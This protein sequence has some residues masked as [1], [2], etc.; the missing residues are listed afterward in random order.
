ME[1]LSAVEKSLPKTMRTTWQEK[2]LRAR[3]SIFGGANPAFAS[4]TVLIAALKHAASYKI[5]GLVPVRSQG[6]KTLFSK[7]QTA[8]LFSSGI[9]VRMPSRASKEGSGLSCLESQET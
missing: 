7:V 4:T 2:V 1:A 8:G 9:P 6:L 3:E 5:F